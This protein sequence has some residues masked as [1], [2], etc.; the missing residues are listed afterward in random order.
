MS[1]I[2]FVSR[3]GTAANDE[4]HAD[5]THDSGTDTYFVVNSILGGDGD[6]TLYALPSPLPVGDQSISFVSSLNGGADNDHLHG[7]SGNDLLDGGAG[8]NILEGGDGNDTFSSVG[9]NQIFGGNGDDVVSFGG[10]SGAIDG[11]DGID[12]VQYGTGDL[13]SYT[14]QDV[15]ILD[16]HGNGVIVS[17]IAAFSAFGTI[18]NTGP[19]AQPD[20]RLAFALRGAGGTLDLSSRLT[21]SRSVNVFDVGSGLTSAVTIVGTS[22]NDILSGSQVGDDILYGGDGNDILSTT[23]G[24]DTLYGGNGDDTFKS[25]GGSQGTID[26][27]A[28]T[29]TAQFVGNYTFTNM[30][31]LDTGSVNGTTLGYSSF[32]VITSS[33]S[34]ANS[35]IDLYLFGAGGALDLSSRVSGAHSVRAR[36]NGLSAAVQLTGSVND[37]EISGS[38]YDDSLDGAAGNDSLNGLAGNDTVSY[39]AAGAGVTVSLAISAAQDTIGAGI[40]ILASFENLTGSAFDDTLTGNNAANRLEGGGGN[41]SLDGGSG[42]DTMAGGN[43]NDTYRV[44]TEGDV[45]TEAANEGIDTVRTAL[46]VYTLGANVENLVHLGAGN[47][48]GTG[49]GLDNTLSGGAGDD[50]LAGEAGSDTASYSLAAAGVTVRLSIAGPQNTVG[51]GL[52]TLTGIENVTGSGSNDVLAGDAGNNVLN[53]GGGDDL[54]EGGLGNDT[55]IGAGG[56]N[57]ATYAA[58]GTGVTVDLHLSA[59]QDTGGAGWDT[60][61]GIDGLI[62][63]GHD[64]TLTGRTGANTL[65]GGAGNDTLDGGS[66]VDS[67]D[68][69]L[70]NDTYWVDNADDVVTERAN[71]GIDLVLTTASKYSLSRQVE[72]LTYAGSGQFTGT[73]NTSDNVITGGAGDDTLTGG[74]GN[75]TLDGAGGSD[76]ASYRSAVSAVTA[77]LA[78]AGPQATGGAGVDTLASIENLTGSSFNDVLTGDGS[79]NTLDGRDGSDQLDGGA[80]ADTMIGGEGDDTYRVDNAGDRVTEKAG[81]GTDTVETTL[82]T[83]LLAANVE[84]LTFTGAGSFSGTGNALDNGLTGGAGDD[85]LAGGAGADALNGGGGIDIASYAG[86]KAAVTA[87]LA[88]PGGNTGDAAGDSYDS[89]EGLRGSRYADTLVG[90]DGDNVITGGGGLDS[91]TGGLGADTFL[92]DQTLKDGNVATLNDLAAGIDKIGLA[93]AI[94]SAAGPAGALNANA[95]RI[96]SKALDADDRIIYD[97]VSGVLLYDSNGSGGG[98]LHAFANVGAGLALTAADFQLV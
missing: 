49:N 25:G 76:T 87:S 9:N 92:F 90:D 79:A 36:D 38:A 24:N 43:G 73:G 55:L 3:G 13:E 27:G 91:L 17:T 6:D 22:R 60:L 58:A 47:F 57:T 34:P 52:D 97:D 70:G 59:A 69:G 31:V 72:K 83:Y 93:L 84:T 62:G 16:Y 15:E 77:S 5:V 20:E 71:Q 65:L 56:V 66:G 14:Y 33:G 95:F 75:D 23:T 7:S 53:G 2:V 89:I 88:A 30:E 35:Q 85:T 32:S 78:I 45:V 96:G 82:A 19:G 50:I 64:D 63:S 4:L 41:D 42:N 46:A 61:S 81:N 10:G 94:F 51:A 12:A 11:G 67:L 80:G 18:T 86:A 26:G 39:A 44:D 74:D 54:L 37:D 40:D 8:S 1:S 29:D 68:G 28:G 21:D 98:G 48:E